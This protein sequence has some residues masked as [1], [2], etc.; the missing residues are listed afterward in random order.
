MYLL[1]RAFAKL[2]GW[3]LRARQPWDTSKPV[4]FDVEL[5]LDT[6]ISNADAR[7]W[8][9]TW[10]EQG[11]PKQTRLISELN[12]Y[13]RVRARFS[14]E[15]DEPLLLL[16]DYLAGVYHHADP[17]AQLGA[18]VAGPEEASQAIHELRR[19]HGTLLYEDTEDFNEEYP[20]DHE[21]GNVVG[22]WT[23]RRVGEG[24]SELP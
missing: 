10:L 11:W 24:P 13:P 2:I 21:K 15:Q 6:D 9:T 16:P 8:F 20:L 12:V 22:R 1:S 18:P 17:R 14:T 19:R 7:E 4:I 5:V 3:L 23:K